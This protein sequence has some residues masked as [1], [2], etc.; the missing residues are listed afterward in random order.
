MLLLQTVCSRL[1]GEERPTKK[2]SSLKRTCVH[3]A[4]NDPVSKSWSTFVFACIWT[5]AWNISTYISLRLQLKQLL[6]SLFDWIQFLMIHFVNVSLIVDIWAENSRAR[7]LVFVVF[8]QCFSQNMMQSRRV[9]QPTA[10]LVLYVWEEEDDI[11][12]MKRQNRV[13][14]S[15]DSSASN[16]K[17]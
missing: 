7:L 2:P 5:W 12:M 1:R 10:C 15:L 9:S 6:L 13:F 11:I 8:I 17:P 14:I 16:S 3:S 4:G